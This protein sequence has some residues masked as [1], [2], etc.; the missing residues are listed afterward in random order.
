MKLSKT[1][2]HKEGQQFT[3]SCESP[4]WCYLQRAVQLC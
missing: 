4:H 2:F 3:L 1:K